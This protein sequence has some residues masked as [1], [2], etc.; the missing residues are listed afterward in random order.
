ML[1]I[2][3][4]E[5]DNWRRSRTIIVNFEHISDLSLV[6]QVVFKRVFIC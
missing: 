1:R 5:R 4:P 2:K 3:T 6:F